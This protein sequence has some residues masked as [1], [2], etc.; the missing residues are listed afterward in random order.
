[1]SK[2]TKDGLTWSGTGCFRAVPVW[3]DC[4]LCVVE[5]QASDS[6][7]SVD[8]TV[9]VVE[10]A[11]LRPSKSESDRCHP[12]GLHDAETVGREDSAW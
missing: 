12:A 7:V 4:W 11:E 10:P 8:W 2:I 9:Y 5:D 1:M 3:Q 6:S